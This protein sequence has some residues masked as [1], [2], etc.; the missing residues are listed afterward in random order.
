MSLDAILQAITASGEEQVR[1][2]KGR[3]SAQVDELFNAAH[4]EASQ[5]KKQA[6]DQAVAPATRERSRIIHRA[7]LEALQTTGNLRE[8]LVDT[9]L[10]QARERLPGVRGEAV[11]AD[12]FCR[13]VQETL[14]ELGISSGAGGFACLRI[15][16]RDRDL[17]ESIQ[18]E[19]NS[20]LLIEYNLNCLG[21]V[22]GRSEDGRVE[23]INTL[24]ARL[25][26]A[27]PY[28][29]RYLAALFEEKEC[30]ISTTVTPAYVP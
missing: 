13:L 21:G 11:Y 25:D 7:K 22:V 3:A 9:A 30:Q 20:R 10:K 16:P 5:V 12:V 29:R 17:M 24:E 4:L 23:V 1:Q 14:A 18:A 19:M 6:F 28:L 26:R 27:S 8:T 2:I 15:D